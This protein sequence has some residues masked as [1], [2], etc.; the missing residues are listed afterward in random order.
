MAAKCT[1]SYVELVV[2]RLGTSQVHG[3]EDLTPFLFC[4]VFFFYFSLFFNDQ[5]AKYTVVWMGNNKTKLQSQ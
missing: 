5:K 4:F 2:H 1:G 3:P